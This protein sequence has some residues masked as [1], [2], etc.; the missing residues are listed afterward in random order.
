MIKV[1]GMK[2]QSRVLLAGL[3]AACVVSANAQTKPA[4]PAA[5]AE[6]ARPADA[7]TQKAETLTLE[8]IGESKDIGGLT[9]LSEVYNSI[10]D[11]PRFTRTVQRLTELL[12][13]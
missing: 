6:A 8:Q 7:L 11:V 12:P 5:N 4:A 9:K 2:I 1:A 13:D 3:L 10:G